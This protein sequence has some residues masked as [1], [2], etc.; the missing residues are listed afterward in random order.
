MTAEQTLIQNERVISSGR[1]QRSRHGV[2]R[3][4]HP[5]PVEPRGE[6]RDALIDAADQLM[7]TRGVAALTTR[8]I[9]RQAGCSDGALYVHFADKAHLLAAACERWIPDL[10]AATGDLVNRVGAGTVAKNLEEIALAALE[11]F[12]E[13]APLSYAIA[14]DPEL[15]ASHRAIVR[16]RGLGP[17][18]G[19]AAVSSYLAAEQRVGRVRADASIDVAASMLTG[20]CWHRAAARHYF[21]EDVVPVDDAT[22]A[23]QLARTLAAA[24]EPATTATDRQPNGGRA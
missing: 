23:A 21:G 4:L 16:A 10:L 5:D 1:R 17:K 19:V 11:A 3:A 13:M 2:R 24:L 6:L 18:R 12:A 14:G 15:L 9:A 22:Y 20:S 7:R 8:E